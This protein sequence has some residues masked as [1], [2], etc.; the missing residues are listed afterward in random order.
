[1]NRILLYIGVLLWACALQAQDYTSS[2]KKAIRLFENGQKAL[3]QGKSDAALNY[4]EQAVA[5]DE[6]FLEAHLMLAELWQDVATSYADLDGN[7][8]APS[9]RVYRE[10]ARKH[11]YAV[12]DKRRDFF[13]PAWANLGRLELA[14]GNYDKAIG[15]YETYLSLDKDGGEL[16]AEAKRDLASARFRKEAVAHP[17]PFNPQNMGAAV[18]SSSDEYLPALTADGKTLV[19]TRRLPRRASTTA[20]TPEEE[21]F[22]LS[23]RENGQWTKAE[24]MPEPVNSNDNEGAQ[25]ISQDGRIM[26]FTAC[27]R[28]GGA[29]RCDLYMCIR[30]GDQWGK[31]RNLGAQVNSGA[32]ESQPSFSIDGKTLY[33]VSDRRGGQGGMDLWR[34]VFE[35]GAWRTPENLGPEIN[36]AGNEMTPFIS[37]DDKTLYFSSNGHPGM[38]GMDLFVSH[39]QADGSWSKPENLGYPINDSGDETGLIVS[40][41]GRTAL[42][43]SQREGGYGKQDLWFFELPEAVRPT[44]AICFTGTVTDAKSSKKVA[45]DIKVIDIN[46]GR[47]VANT[48]SDAQSGQYIVSLPADGAY[49]FHVSADGYLLHSQSEVWKRDD[50][51]E[52]WKP[53][54]VDIALH[55][56]ESGE[57]I[58]LRN[59]FFETGRWELLEGSQYELDKVVELLSRNPQLRIELGGHTDNVGR[60]EAN[61]KLSEQRAKAVYDYLTGKGIAKERLSYKGYGE[62]QP[63]AGNDTEEGRSEN[64]RTEIKVL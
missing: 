11:Y 43:A 34:T 30:R 31:P 61:Q 35:N 6:D 24:R 1:M 12:T 13:V 22:Y 10:K 37:Y 17:V 8:Q 33:F 53:I 42:Y 54:T 21:D 28:Q 18:N 50:N 25:C 57:R 63:V 16:Q 29:G 62:T 9:A 51:Y 14:D 2:D 52:N 4:F 3:Y 48:S 20:R 55:P 64:R 15:C 39:R 60:P 32:W 41:D 46:E 23:R 56:I 58:A 49:A 36:S 7:A 45:A 5:A 26:F 19:F 44:V 59:V 47:V 38:G 27:D 40:A